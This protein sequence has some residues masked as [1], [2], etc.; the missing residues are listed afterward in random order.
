MLVAAFRSEPRTFNRFVSPYAAEELVSRLTQATLVRMNRVTGALE[1]RLAQAWQPSADGRTWTLTLRPNV[2]FSDGAPFTSADVLFTFAVLYDAKVGSDLADSLK[3]DGRP[4]QAAAPSADTVVLTFPAPYGPGIGLLDSLPILPKHQLL[5]AFEH[6]AFR[7]AWGVSAP[8]GTMAGLGPFV[9]TDYTPGRRL[10][11]DRNPHF[12]AID[13]R[14]AA[15]PYLDRLAIDIVP[16]PNAELLRFEA[17]Q[18][19]MLNGRV[20]PEDI[21]A[22]ERLSRDG[23]VA[24]AQAGTGINSD[25]LWFNLGPH[26]PRDRPWLQREE[27]RRAIS[28]AVDRAVIVNTVY[29]SAAVP[30]FG[31][32]TPGGGPWYDA[33]LPHERYDTRR[34]ADLL[35]AIGLVDRNGDRILDDAGGRPARFT[36]LTG[37]DDTLRQRTMEIVQRQLAA[38]GLQVDIAALDGRTT[39]DRWSRGDYDA[40]YYPIFFDALDPSRTLE[41]WLSSGGFHVWNPGQA[42]PATAWEADIDRGMRA[43]SS[44]TDQAERQRLFRGVQ[45]TFAAHLP[46]LYF[47]APQVTIALSTRVHGARPSVLSPEVLWNAESLWVSPG[48]P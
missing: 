11:F 10:Q 31:P 32:I 5:D 6:G 20:R 22:L 33:S 41:Y 29:L 27:L 43:V 36:I 35:R 38:V 37:R 8:P 15:L 13:A 39:I 9:L 2:E 24:L 42:A 1:P 21:A 3:I 4:I 26:T 46:V 14:G 40:I 18:L 25:G 30:V 45:A 34:A 7:Q 48:Q 47:V 16:D 12:W 19:D 17:G 28:A 23:R 44:T